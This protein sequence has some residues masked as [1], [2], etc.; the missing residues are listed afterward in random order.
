MAKPHVIVL[1]ITH[2]K[3]S[4]QQVSQKYSVSIRWI[5]VLLKRYA[6]GG[7]EALEP[8]S[9][10]PHTSPGRISDDLVQA[11]LDARYTL[12]ELGLDNGPR[13]IAWR[14]QDQGIKPPSVSSI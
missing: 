5:N 13:T 8:V 14:L 9:R 2:Q 7:V 3:L 12:T 1:S 11:V 10:R 4:K 6:D